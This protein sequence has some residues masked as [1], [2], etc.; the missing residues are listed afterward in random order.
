MHLT[1]TMAVKSKAEFVSIVGASRSGT[2]LM[3]RILNKSG[4]IAISYENH[5]LGHV[6]KSEGALYKFRKFGDLSND[7]NVIH[8]TNYIYSGEF[9]SDS[10]YR[11]ISRH[12]KWI[13]QNIN[14]DLI[15]D[16]ILKSDRSERD[17]FVVMMQAYAEYYGKAII[18]E[19]TPI[20][21]RHVKKLFEWF[22]NGRIIH[23]LRDPRAVYVSELR[24][25]KDRPISTPYKQLKHFQ[26]FFQIF[27]L[28]QT[29]L[30]WYES[31][32]KSRINFKRYK[33]KYIVLKFEDLIKD[34]EMTIKEVCSFIGIQFEENMMDQ[35][36]ISKGFL[37]GQSG[38][39]RFASRRWE[40]QI[41]W[42]TNRW[43]S[44]LFYQQLRK[45]GYLNK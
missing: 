26:I 5:Y 28:L 32:R 34:P 9:E 27:I 29:T 13:I 6:I 41:D 11:G 2:T 25:R 17:L 24:R 15:L 20:H 45:M 40:N 12:W 19:K 18:G 44:L 21:I 42:P 14:K 7:N 35:K 1:K 8:L 22:P 23:L 10:K 39:D 38:F 43:F 3:R 36:V 30:L 16:K 37:E 4:E 33:K 31:Y